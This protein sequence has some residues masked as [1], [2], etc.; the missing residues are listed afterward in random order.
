MC[1]SE[2]TVATKEG[3]NKKFLQRLQ[4]K[5]GEI[6]FL[7]YGILWISPFSGEDI[8]KVK[9]RADQDMYQYKKERKNRKRLS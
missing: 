5:R 8:V 2:K 7:T 1:S 9:D 3:V 4:E 6:A